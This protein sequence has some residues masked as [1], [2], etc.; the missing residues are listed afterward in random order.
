MQTTFR[1]PLN[2]ARDTI[3]AWSTCG[4]AFLLGPVY[5]TVV[6]AWAAAVILWVLAVTAVMSSSTDVMLVAAAAWAVLAVM[7]FSIRARLYRQR[8]WVEV[9]PAH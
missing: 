6:G 8:G 1:H 7:A 3:S 4:P 5:F 2:G 9:Q